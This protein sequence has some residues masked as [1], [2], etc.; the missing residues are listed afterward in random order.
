MLK[1]FNELRELDLS[2]Y[3]KKEMAQTICRGRYV[4]TFCISTALNMLTLN[5]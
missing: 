2:Q 3:I 5:R 4:L 1:G